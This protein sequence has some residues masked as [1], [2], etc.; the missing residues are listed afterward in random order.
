MCRLSQLAIQ[1]NAPELASLADRIS[2]PSG[3][4]IPVSE[5]TLQPDPPVPPRAVVARMSL[6]LRQLEREIANGMETISSNR[7]GG[8]LGLTD[9]QVRKDLGWFGQ[10]GYRGIGYRCHELAGRIRESLGTSRTW[11]VA[12]VGCG[13]LGQALLGYG[14]FSRQGFQVRAAFDTDPGVIGQSL[15][16]IRIEDFAEFRNSV[17]REQIELVMLAVPADQA[18]R[19]AV[20]IARSGVAGILNFAPTLLNLAGGIAVSNVD[21]TIELEQLAFAVVQNRKKR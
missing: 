16:G 6:Y 3:F 14:G 10:M 8:L 1:S 13:H 5:P 2:D 7:L 12:L 17:K 19:T 4:P 9:S 18:E 15:R 11:P 21:L 20:E